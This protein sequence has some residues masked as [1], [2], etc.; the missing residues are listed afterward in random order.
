[1]S[2]EVD[3]LLPWD[4]LKHNQLLLNIL[5]PWFFGNTSRPF[6]YIPCFL[7]AVFDSFELLDTVT[8][9]FEICFG[10]IL[11]NHYHIVL[12]NHIHPLYN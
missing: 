5:S 2:D 8:S 7:F 4:S 3:G 9:L 1:M 10:N 12:G 6:S 11:E